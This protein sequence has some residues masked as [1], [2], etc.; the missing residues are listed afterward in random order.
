MRATKISFLR[1][2][3]SMN[4]FIIILVASAIMASNALANPLEAI[5]KWAIWSA[6]PKPVM[7]SLA[8]KAEPALVQAMKDDLP[9]A[10]KVQLNT[11]AYVGSS[12]NNQHVYVKGVSAKP[13]MVTYPQF[14]GF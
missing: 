7:V 14:H 1:G 13:L 10:V 8:R 5:A 9:E 6:R 2:N 11:F 3:L 4:P 12:R